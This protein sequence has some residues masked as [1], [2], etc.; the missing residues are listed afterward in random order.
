M[1]LNITRTFGI[2]FVP[3]LFEGMHTRP[4]YLEAAWELFKEDLGLE[5]LDGR[6]KQIIALAITTNDAGTYYIAAWSHAFRLNALDPATC[7]KL[8]LT[9]RFFNSF[10]R[11]V[12]EVTPVSAPQA[13][14]FVSHGLRDEYQRYEAKRARQLRLSKEEDQPTTSWIGGMLWV[15]FSCRS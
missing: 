15:I 13:S 12:S 11:Y 6:T 14:I 2:S 9:T 8:L 3:D 10:E 1:F 7:D 5:S 4:A